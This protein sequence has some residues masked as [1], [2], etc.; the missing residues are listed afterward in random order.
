MTYLAKRF[1]EFAQQAAKGDRAEVR[2]LDEIGLSDWLGRNPCL[3]TD[4]ARIA[5]DAF[6]TTVAAHGGRGFITV[7]KATIAFARDQNCQVWT[8]R[9]PA[10]R[11][12][13]EALNS[14]EED[15]VSAFFEFMP[16]M[17]S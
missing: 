7:M 4:P 5:C 16:P 13:S 3:E 17:N 2:Q 8:H 14:A 10:L 12:V 6:L 11:D 1:F 15:I 9:L